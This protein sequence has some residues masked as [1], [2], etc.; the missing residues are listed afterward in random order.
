MRWLTDRLG[1]IFDWGF[2]LRHGKVSHEWDRMLNWFLD[3][4]DQ[5]PIQKG[6]SYTLAIGEL[7][8][9]ADNYP[10]AYGSLW[11]PHIRRALPRRATAKRLR[12]LQL[13]LDRDLEAEALREA[14]NKTRGE[15]S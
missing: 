11:E 6:S 12:R 2:W 13:Q 7:R 9:W 15:S 10:Y 8:I 4:Q 3:R 14:F 5:Y 1:V